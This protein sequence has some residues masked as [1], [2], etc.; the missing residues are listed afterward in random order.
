MPRL[1]AA[2]VGLAFLAGASAARADGKFFVPDIGRVPIPDQQALIHW[3]DGVETLAIETRY[4]S[5]ATDIAWVI[6]LPAEPE[7]TPATTGMFPTL[8]TTFTPRVAHRHPLSN[9]DFLLVILLLPVVLVVGGKRFFALVALF[10]GILLSGILLPALGTAGTSRVG[11]DAVRIHQREIVGDYNATVISG[12]DAAAVGQWLAD[13]RYTVSPD[14]RAALD[15]YVA[16]GWVFAA[17]R[18]RPTKQSTAKPRTAH[19]LIFRFAADEP[20]YPM[21]LTGAQGDDLTLDLY[22][23]ADHR[24]EADAMAVRACVEMV[25]AD[26]EHE[27]WLGNGLI[28]HPRLR[29]LVGDRK[30][31]GTHL[32]AKLAPADMQ[33]DITIQWTDF[34]RKEAIFYTPGAAWRA[35]LTGGLLV[36]MGMMVSIGLAIRRGVKTIRPVAPAMAGWLGAAIIVIVAVRLALPVTD[37]S[38]PWTAGLQSRSFHRQ[39]PGF[40][41]AL[42][43]DYDPGDPIEAAD[44]DRLIDRALA[45]EHW[46]EASVTNPLTGERIGYEDSPGNYTLEQTD[47]G[48]IY[49]WYDMAGVPHRVPLWDTGSQ[50]PAWLDGKG[51]G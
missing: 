50:R 41:E 37:D 21:R 19:P 29:A 7:I 30:M 33:R 39:L 8:R 25:P 10:V 24:A 20:V 32:S 11:G 51:R 47:K 27:H 34:D 3:N 31:I 5:D 43:P 15:R 48:T 17:V 9:F 49:I 2:I 1:A 14:A 13:N 18:L 45:E 35:G 22:V 44:I 28:G 36:M 40:L 6:P 42:M 26:D 12:D 23:F 38:I 46:A 4:E 16:D